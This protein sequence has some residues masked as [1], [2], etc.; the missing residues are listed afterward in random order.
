VSGQSAEADGVASG[1][2][3]ILYAAG[4]ASG[5]LDL[6]AQMA[7]VPA[8][9]AVE[10]DASATA[11]GQHETRGV[12]A[13]EINRLA[14]RY[15]NGDRAALAGLHAAVAPVLRSALRR[16]VWRGLPGALQLADLDQQSWLI[17]A[18]L[19]ERWEP[20]QGVDFAAYVGCT[21]PWAL[22]RYLR[23]QSPERR[24]QGCQVFSRAH[25]RVVAALEEA[26]DT[27][28][29]DWDEALYC[30]E[31]LREIEPRARAAL[32]LHAVECRSFSDVA[33]QLGVPRGTAYDL[34]CRAIATAR[35]A[36]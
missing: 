19:A 20:R 30:G 29:R 21:F 10:S 27:D 34:Y 24:A 8:G 23:S 13:D 4:V 12:Q 18:T 32:W 1:Q 7:V 3:L 9:R 14:R 15:Q 16:S 36:A 11:S 17:L 28:G 5:G 22:A 35:R 33:E 25:E 6:E 2:Q 26:A 31:L